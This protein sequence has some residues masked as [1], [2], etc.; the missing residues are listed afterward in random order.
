MA[1]GM[2]VALVTGCAG[3]IGAACCR[4]LSDQGWAV[5]GVDIN[6]GATPSAVR[7]IEADLSDSSTPERVIENVSREA[8]RLDVLVNNA[9]A[10]LCASIEETTAEQIDHVLAVNVRAPMLMMRHAVAML[11]RS[12]G[13][14]V[15]IASVH[16]TATSRDIAAYAA[17][18]GALV[19]LSRAASLEFAEDGVR[20][21]AVL[22]GATDTPMLR[23]GL[24]RDHAGDGD[25]DDRLR[26]L[27]SRHPIGRVA[28]A[29]EIARA[30]LFLADNE[31]SSFITGQTLTV[32][33]GALA[34][35][36][37]E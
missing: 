19:A 33:G 9:A 26:V 2:R 5:V 23:S 6:R 22:P 14:I 29:D 4:L 18:K 31:Q 25:T 3:G 20:V 37:T 10:Q 1:G 27:A 24:S 12:R 28:R 35:L 16:A 11:R 7:F 32:D 30:V 13:T 36:S 17:S 8:G 15:N 34:R 21:N